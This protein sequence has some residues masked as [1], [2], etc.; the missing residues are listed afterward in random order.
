MA[1]ENCGI[2]FIWRCLQWWWIFETRKNTSRRI[3]LEEFLKI[4]YIQ[5]CIKVWSVPI[6]FGP[7]GSIKIWSVC[8]F[9][10]VRHSKR[11]VYRSWKD[12]CESLTDGVSNFHW[13]I[14]WLC[15]WC[16]F[17]GFFTKSKQNGHTK[18]LEINAHIFYITIWRRY[19]LWNWS[20]EHIG[21]VG[22]SE[23][24]SG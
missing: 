23:L 8:I 22:P 9:S 18:L 21:R 15:E 6:T 4:S 5:I 11:Q 2:R 1:P 17:L 19:G 10:A 20:Y 24:S 13:K 3:C 12:W 7:I 16:S 14:G